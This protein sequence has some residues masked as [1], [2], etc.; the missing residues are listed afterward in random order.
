M[1]RISWAKVAMDVFWTL[2]TANPM[3][4]GGQS[5]Q[6]QGTAEASSYKEVFFGCPDDT[7]AAGFLFS[8]CHYFLSTCLAMRTIDEVD[9]IAL[10]QR[11]ISQLYPTPTLLLVLGELGVS[12]DVPLDVL[13]RL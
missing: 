10:T 8:K 3:E 12:E 9:S 6:R 11:I 5:R 7:V 2:P 4:N 13:F 1:G